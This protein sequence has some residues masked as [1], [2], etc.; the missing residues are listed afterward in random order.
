MTSSGMGSTKQSKL[1][2]WPMETVT[3]AAASVPSC[4][5][6][7]PLVKTHSTNDTTQLLIVQN[8]LLEK[9][10]TDTWEE[11]SIK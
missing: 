3:Q 5:K 11:R 2:I 9:Q 10:T 7:E 4:P 1:S 6:V 8:R